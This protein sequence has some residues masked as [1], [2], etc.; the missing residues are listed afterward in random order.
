MELTPKISL[1]LWKSEKYR[2]INGYLAESF[3]MDYVKKE[4]DIEFD[5]YLYKIKDVVNMIKSI[6]VPFGDL[7]SKFKYKNIFYRGDNYKNLVSSS[8]NKET[9]ISV[10]SD[11]ETAISFKD[12]GILYK[13]IIDDDVLVCKTGIESEILIEPNSL[14]KYLK[15]DKHYVY[16]NIKSYCKEYPSY[17]ELLL[18]FN[19]TIYPIKEH[20]KDLTISSN[21]IKNLID[22]FNIF[23]EENYEIKEFEFDL[24]SMNIIYDNNEDLILLFN[25]YK[26]IKSKQNGG[27]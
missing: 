18:E 7:K 20:V 2:L 23:K 15:S 14:F 21:R 1:L 27:I 17:A 5:K 26:E 10:T 13:I 4:T 9:F 8:Y 11:L 22:E 16:I 19:K 6:M 3:Y 24:K 12:D 25:F